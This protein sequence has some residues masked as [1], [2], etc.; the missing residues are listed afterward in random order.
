MTGTNRLASVALMAILTAVFCRPGLAEARCVPLHDGVEYRAFLPDG[1]RFVYVD[2]KVLPGVFPTVFVIADKNYETPAKLAQNDPLNQW[3][4]DRTRPFT[5][6]ADKVRIRWKA[7]HTF[8][9]ITDWFSESGPKELAQSIRGVEKQGERF[10]GTGAYDT[11]SF[12]FQT[13]LDMTGFTDDV[14]EVLA[15]AVTYEGVTVTPPIVIF[16]RSDDG[17]K[18]KC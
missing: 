11:N 6:T 1:Q 14:F 8:D 12:A 13:R 4:I 17:F 9:F 7:N 16:E 15:P 2:F 3:W 18:T 10:G 5:F